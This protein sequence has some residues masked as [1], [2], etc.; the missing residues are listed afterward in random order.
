MTIVTKFQENDK[1]F[2][3]HNS[4]VIDS[5]VRGFKIERL[6]NG[7]DGHNTLITYFC[8]R[9]PELKVSVKVEE[10]NAFPTKED[11]LKSL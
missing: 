10:E 11:L 7:L 3:L 9:E 2:F 1:V 4:K 8:A 6:P 5:I